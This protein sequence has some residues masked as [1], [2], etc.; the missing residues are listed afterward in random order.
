[1]KL[2]KLWISRHNQV[3]KNPFQTGIHLPPSNQSWHLCWSS[4]WWPG[5]HNRLPYARHMFLSPYLISYN[6]QDTHGIFKRSTS[7]QPT[8]SF[9]KSL[10][11]TKDWPQSKY[12]NGATPLWRVPKAALSLSQFDATQLRMRSLA[13]MCKAS[14]GWLAGIEPNV[15]W[16]SLANFTITLPFYG[17]KLF[18][19]LSL[20]PVSKASRP[21]PCNLIGSLHQCG[22]VR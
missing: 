5:L 11:Y 14:K 17:C 19:L 7:S 20:F 4:P 3:S 1:M 13:N 15:F 12:H 16:C 22:R 6:D 9:Q 8:Q 18:C 2:E 10:S 21:Q